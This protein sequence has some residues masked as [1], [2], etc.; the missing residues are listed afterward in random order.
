MPVPAFPDVNGV[1]TSYCSI[2]LVLRGVRLK[3]VKSINYRESHEIGKIRGISSHP[4]GRTRGMVDFE[5]DIELYHS[6]WLMLLPILTNGGLVGFAE[7]SSPVS[8]TY[9]ELPVAPAYE[10]VQDILEG[11]RLHSPESSAAEGVEAQVIKLSMSI[12]NILWGR[13]VHQGLRTRL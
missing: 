8:I 9:S 11:V 1:K 7:V 4:I 3:G 10:T 13:G 12:M 2:E 6:E 5:G